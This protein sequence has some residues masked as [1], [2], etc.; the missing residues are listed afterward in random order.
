M[1]LYWIMLL[2][3]LSSHCALSRDW[4]WFLP[5]NTPVK[6]MARIY[7]TTV[8]TS[9]K[10]MDVATPKKQEPKKYGKAAHNNMTLSCY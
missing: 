3:L 6:I 7:T 1:Y 10:M 9:H 5:V 8:N 4:V 2:L